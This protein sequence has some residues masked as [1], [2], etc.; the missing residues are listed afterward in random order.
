M[1]QCVCVC[2][3]VCMCVCRHLFRT[4]ILRKDGTLIVHRVI[5]PMKIAWGFPCVILSSGEKSEM[6]R[7]KTVRKVK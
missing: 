1:W 6:A 4:K 2:V 5:S 3:C 7:L